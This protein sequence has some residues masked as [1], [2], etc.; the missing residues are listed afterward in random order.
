M[1]VP[2]SFYIVVSYSRSNPK[3]LTAS[4]PDARLAVELTNTGSAA[5]SFCLRITF[6]SK[7]QF[8]TRF[9]HDDNNPSASGSDSGSNT[10]SLKSSISHAAKLMRLATCTNTSAIDR[11]KAAKWWCQRPMFYEG[12]FQVL[13]LAVTLVSIP[14]NIDDINSQ[15]FLATYIEAPPLSMFK[16]ERC[17]I[18]C[19]SL[20]DKSFLGHVVLDSCLRMS[21]D[22]KELLPFTRLVTISLNSLD[23]LESLSGLRSCTELKVLRVY[24]CPKLRD[25]A[26][27]QHL[28]NLWELDLNE[29]AITSLVP[30]EDDAPLS[31]S[32]IGETVQGQLEVVRVMNCAG[33]A[34]LRFLRHHPHI[35]S[36]SLTRLP[37]THLNWLCCQGELKQLVLQSLPALW[38]GPHGQDGALS[39]PFLKRLILDDPHPESDLGFLAQCINLEE[40]QLRWWNH[41]VGW[42]P[43]G[44]LRFLKTLRISNNDSLRA[45]NWIH[46]C[47]QIKVLHL[48]MNLFLQD[49]SPIASLLSLE[50]L[51][52][53][54][55]KVM[56]GHITC[57]SAKCSKLWRV[58][59]DN[60]RLLSDLSSLG[61]LSNLSVFSASNT[62]ITSIDWIVNC[63][64]LTKVS[65]QNCSELKDRSP[66]NYL[67]VLRTCDL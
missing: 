21:R 56:D 35:L 25:L 48:S 18:E 27:I 12:S 24:S 50:Q 36:I 52:L 46:Q 33:L 4:H 9:V 60:C 31:A 59:L 67:P 3:A 61:Q 63:V 28:S 16:L 43:I 19:L 30:G 39:L 44:H 5:D 17:G 38:W 8:F 29:L 66:L 54:A 20:A 2:Y 26:V 37:L 41:D 55:T 13:P 22:L 34:D 57:I 23:Q 47:S 51:N 10:S 15:L 40:L 53:N 11:L 49:F 6:L 14:F 45:L 42:G 58:I 7:D 1:S 64:H 32:E 62:R 65:L